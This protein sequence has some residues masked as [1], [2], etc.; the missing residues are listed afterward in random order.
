VVKNKKIKNVYNIKDKEQ[1]KA[2]IGSKNSTGN[3]RKCF[4][5]SSK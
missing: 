5:K 4:G 1:A 3:I 2:F